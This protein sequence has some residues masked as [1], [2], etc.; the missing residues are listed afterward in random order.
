[1]S[2]MIS[3]KGS[4]GSPGFCAAPASATIEPVVRSVNWV[5]SGHSN[6]NCN[7]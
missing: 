5:T 4:N 1:M 7:Q 2:S 3:R 6:T